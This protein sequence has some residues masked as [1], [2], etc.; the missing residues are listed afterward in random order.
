MKLLFREINT[1]RISHLT[2]R[3]AYWTLLLYDFL[4]SICFFIIW[5][6][7]SVFIRWYPT[8][9][10]DTFLH[11]FFHDNMNCRDLKQ[12]FWDPRLRIKNL[13]SRGSNNRKSNYNHS[14]K[15]KM[16][17]TMTRIILWT[18]SYKFVHSGY[19]RKD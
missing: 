17:D 15:I 11:L 18:K 6:D 12:L 5:W 7:S 10:V 13:V 16:W 8:E 1:Q 4:N 19:M 9:K 14:R 2:R 3:G